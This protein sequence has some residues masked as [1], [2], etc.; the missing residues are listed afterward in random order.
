MGMTG[1]LGKMN[2]TS[3]RFCLWRQRSTASAH[4]AP[5]SP[6][7]CAKMTVAVCRPLAGKM[8]GA[9]LRTEDIVLVVVVAVVDDSGDD[10]CVAEK[11]RSCGK[12]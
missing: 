6:R 2:L 12:K 7:P 10:D 9:A 4:P 8:S 11:S 5:E 1:A 3:L